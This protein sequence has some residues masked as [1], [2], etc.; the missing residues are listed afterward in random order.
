MSARDLDALLER[1]VALEA[2]DLHLGAG[3][4]PI[5][6]REGLLEPLGDEPALEADELDALALALLEPEQRAAFVRERTVDLAYSLPSGARFRLNLFAERVGTG[7]AVR[8][9]DERLRGL[10]ELRLPASLTRLATLDDGLVVVTGPTG[11]GKSTT[12]AAL[13]DLINAQ[14]PAHVITL[15]D[16]IEY[17]HT[18]RRALVRQRQ[19]HTHFPA[20]PEA[21]RAA[22]RE[23]PDVLLVG[24]MRDLETLRI[25]LMAAE[26]G[27]LVLS[28]L[29]AAGAVGAVERFVGGFPGGERDAV[30]HQ[31]AM[32]LRGVVAQRLVRG[33][34]GARVPAVEVLL[35]TSAIA[36]LIRSGKSAQ[37]QSALESGGALGM[38]TFD[39]SLAD[40]VKRGWLDEASARG[41]TR[42]PQAFADRLRLQRNATGGAPWR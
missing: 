14:R 17:V 10:A 36:N 11:S 20:F 1:C 4:P 9:L 29:H 31:L 23:D 32:V 12:L 39:D 28:T 2:S 34:G 38:Q 13:I 35:A 7:F 22:L 3:Q 25:A 5:V 15:E 37:L 8:R 42:D 6:R 41:A 27:H 21:L 40:A 24:E 16:P 26:T 19:L 30:R 18:S 33:A